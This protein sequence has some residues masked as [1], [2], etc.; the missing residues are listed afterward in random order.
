MRDEMTSDLPL[1]ATLEDIK[2][3]NINS[4]EWYK[5]IKIKINWLYGNKFP[6]ICLACGEKFSLFELHHGIVSRGVARGWVFPEFEELGFLS[7]SVRLILITN[8]VNC[9]PLHANCNKQHAP[10]P[11]KVWDHQVEQYSEELLTWW[12][13]D[14]LPWKDKPFRWFNNDFQS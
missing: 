10:S 12:Y 1:I 14:I 7:K 8:E 13:K 3:K 2:L 9:I 11:Q 5:S 4:A 6:R